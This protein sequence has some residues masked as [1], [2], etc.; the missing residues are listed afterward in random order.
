MLNL[1]PPKGK[2]SV[3]MCVLPIASCRVEVRS[4]PALRNLLKSSAITLKPGDFGINTT[5]LQSSRV[6]SSISKT[7][8]DLDVFETRDF[9]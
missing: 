5:H 2:K 3:C 8:G 9:R 7:S 1:H 6:F 4:Y